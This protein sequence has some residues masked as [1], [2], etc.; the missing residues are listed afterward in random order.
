M[1]ANSH[2]LC[3]H[4]Y[5]HLDEGP[6]PRNPVEW[7]KRR[8]LTRT[9]AEFSALTLSEARQKLQQGLAWFAAQEWQVQGFVPP[10]WMISPAALPA[11]HGLGLEYI[12]LFRGW[13]TLPGLQYVSAPSLTYTT[14]HPLGDALNRGLQSGLLLYERHTPVLRLALHPAD[15][16]RPANLRHALSKLEQLLRTRDCLTERA[17]LQGVSGCP[18]GKH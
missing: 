17:A 16:L 2:E 3:L 1:Q 6:A 14:R 8:L 7:L 4:G 5:T 11:F 13:L 15:A 10:A 9:E 12:G 18:I